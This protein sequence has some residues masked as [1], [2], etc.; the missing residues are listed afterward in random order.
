[1]CL[2]DNV[3]G[4]WFGVLSPDGRYVYYLDDQKGDEIGHLVRIPYEGEAMPEDITPGMQPYAVPF[5]SEVIG[6]AISHSANML[7]FSTATGDGFHLYCTQLD[8]TGKLSE[9]HKL[10]AVEK[11]VIGPRL[12]YDGEIAVLASTEFDEGLQ[13]TLLAFASANSQIVGKLQDQHSSLHPFMFS[14]VKGDMR[15]LATTN[16]TGY[17]RPLLWNPYTGKRLDILLEDLEGEIYPCDWSSDGARLLLKQF[18]RAAPQLYI[19]NIQDATYRRLDHPAYGYIGGACFGS[20]GE[21]FVNCIDS[22]K[23]GQIVALD[24]TTGKQLRVLLATPEPPPG[25]PLRS[26]SFTS[27]DG[28]SIQAWVGVPEGK[29]PFPTILETHGGPDA[30]A[31]G[32]FW[33]WAQ[34]WLDHGFVY[35]TV[36]YRGSTSFGRAFQEQIWG[37][38]GHWEVEDMVAARN[39]LIENAIADPA[40]IFLTGWSY[41]GYLTLHALSIYP[42]LWAG[43]MAGVAIADCVLAYEDEA[44]TLKAYDVTLFKG[45]PQEKPE[46]YRR[47]SPIIYA[48]RVK[49][50]VLIIQGRNDTRCPPRQIEVYEEKMKALGKDIEVHWYD[51]GHVSTDV[52]QQI[53][54]QERMMRFAY[55]VLRI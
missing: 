27:S 18:S 43:G 16:C 3:D 44:D 11:L 38:V 42:D 19:Y 5:E 8:S 32:G 29:G 41:G 33:P 39:W 55:R 34:S 53:A 46:L 22:I 51:A 54:D 12:S 1:R 49:A 7:G 36:N 45:T 52:E 35:I 2:T 4:V 10:Y 14:P 21:L 23:P 31:T 20:T 26:V 30:V 6:L 17:S 28:Q 15:F 37:D 48:E 40:K 25:R 13:Y 47:A 9:L 50:P 24:Q